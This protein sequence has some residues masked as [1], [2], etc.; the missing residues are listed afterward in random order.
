MGGDY[1]HDSIG[2][3][4]DLIWASAAL[5]LTGDNMEPLMKKI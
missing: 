2:E 3:G 4:H 1:N 5:N